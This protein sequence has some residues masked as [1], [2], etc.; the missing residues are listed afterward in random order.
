M[1]SLSGIGSFGV[2]DKIDLRFRGINVTSPNTVIGMQ[3]ANMST[4]R[5]VSQST[6]DDSWAQ[7]AVLTSQSTVTVV[8]A[9]GSYVSLACTNPVTLAFDVSTFPTNGQA[10]VG[11]GLWLGTNSLTKGVGI[12]QTDFDALTLSTTN[13]N[14]LVFRKGDGRIV[15]NVRE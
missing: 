5:L 4:W 2:G 12:D 13:W 7:S 8:R 10:T 6:T 15:F 9:N 3:H 14:D 1:G 11:M